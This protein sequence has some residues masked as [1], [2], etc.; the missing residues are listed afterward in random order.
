MAGFV[1]RRY[2]FWMDDKK[3]VA[4]LLDLLN[5][6]GRQTKTAHQLYGVAADI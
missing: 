1:S 4:H 3:Y 2:L 5:D 6:G